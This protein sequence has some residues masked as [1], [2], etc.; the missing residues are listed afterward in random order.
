M[1]RAVLWTSRVRRDVRLEYRIASVTVV[2]TAHVYITD[3]F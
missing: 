1:P 3:Q 2:Q